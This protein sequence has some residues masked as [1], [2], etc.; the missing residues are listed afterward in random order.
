METEDCFGF[1]ILK[2]GRTGQPPPPPALTSILDDLDFIEA[3][4]VGD[5]N[6]ADS[7]REV[8]RHTKMGGGVSSGP[9][10]GT[11]RNNAKSAEVKAIIN[12]QRDLECR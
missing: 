3:V 2:E 4:R 12:W 5:W 11:A 1:A 8:I 6:G 7:R 10:A 9:N